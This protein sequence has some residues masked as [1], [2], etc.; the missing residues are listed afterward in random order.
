[1]RPAGSCGG[2]GGCQV[3]AEA[4]AG[5]GI[6]TAGGSAGRGIARR[7]TQRRRGCGMGK[8]VQVIEFTTTRGS[9]IEQ[10]YASFADK[11]ASQGRTGGGVVCADR[12]RPNHYF[13]IVNFESYD[14][15]MENSS[16]PDTQEYAER[17]AALCDGP[18]QFYN[19]DVI[20]ELPA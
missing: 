4:G 16:Q 7:G 12:D 19:L 10:L 14:K 8:F 2:L 9:E 13:A 20:R 18:P 3:R 17:F 11:L 1:M 15:A 5:L 6:S